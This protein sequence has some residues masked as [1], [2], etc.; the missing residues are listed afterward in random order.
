MFSSATEAIQTYREEAKE[1]S[2]KPIDQ[3]IPP[4]V[5]AGE[6][7]KPV[8]PIQDDDCVIFF[9]FRGDR[10]IEISRAFTESPKTF[11]FSRDP[12]VKVHYAGMMEYDGDRHIP[13]DYLVEPPATDRTIVRKLKHHA[14]LKKLLC[15]CPAFSRSHFFSSLRVSFWP[16][17]TFPSMPSQKTQKYGHVTYFWQGNN[18]EKFSE[19]YETW[20]EIPS[21]IIPFEEAPR[22]QADK[23]T[24]TL[25]KALKEEAQVL[26]SQLRK[27]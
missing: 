21:D 23:I 25:I 1:D 26:A 4:F 5:I 2:T 16:K 19:Q 27:W 15:S 13:P 22:M 9:N 6:D 11:P 18:S 12:A 8:A 17:M 10:A 24:D 14:A 3:D 7:G 20:V